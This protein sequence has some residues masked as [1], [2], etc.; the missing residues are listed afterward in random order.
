MCIVVEG[1]DLDTIKLTT[2][3]GRKEPNLNRE[4]TIQIQHPVFI[5]K[6]LVD[7]HQL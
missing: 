7:F 6:L 3:L 4:G 1:N 2:W 5:P